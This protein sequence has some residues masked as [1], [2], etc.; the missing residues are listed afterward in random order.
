MFDEVLV[1]NLGKTSAFIS[2]KVDIINIERCGRKRWNNNISSIT[3]TA[4]SITEFNVNLNFVVLKS[5]K[6]KSKTGVSAKPE[7]KRNV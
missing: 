4:S 5:D 7:L 1:R 6:R 3:R 2:V